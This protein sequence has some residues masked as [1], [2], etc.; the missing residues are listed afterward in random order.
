MGDLFRTPVAT[1]G[2]KEPTGSLS[3]QIQNGHPNANKD[4]TMVA[5]LLPTP[6][7]RDYK[8]GYRTEA[9]TRRDGKSRAMDAL[10]NAAIGGIGVEHVNGKL[11]PTWV[12]WLMGFPEGWTD[13]KHWE[14]PS[15]PKSPK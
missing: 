14:T 11:N 8:G 15:S 7:T 12:E 13:L 2:S 10:P 9:L 1:D 4:G 3:K 6:T 5:H